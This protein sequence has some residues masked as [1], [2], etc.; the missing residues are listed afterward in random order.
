MRWE[1]DYLYTWDPTGKWRPT[2][3]ELMLSYSEL[4]VA[5]G[6]VLF[7]TGGTWG[8]I[9]DAGSPLMLA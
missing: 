9:G 3:F 6:D 1:K 5:L 7:E 4:E 8:G 2:G